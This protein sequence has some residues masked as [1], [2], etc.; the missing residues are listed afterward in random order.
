VEDLKQQIDAAVDY[1]NACREQLKKLKVE[2]E[3]ETP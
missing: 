1:A 2:P 3:N